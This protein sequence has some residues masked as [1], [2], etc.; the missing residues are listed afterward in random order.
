[1]NV[2]TTGRVVFALA[3]ATCLVALGGLEVMSERTWVDHERAAVTLR[4]QVGEKDPGWDTITPPD[5]P[6]PALESSHLTMSVQN[7]R[8]TVLT[9]DESAGR[10]RSMS[11]AGHVT[12]SQIGSPTVL[13]TED[14]QTTDLA[15]LRAG[16]IIRVEPTDGTIQRIVLLRHAWQQLE[17][18]EQ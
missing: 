9:M 16:D 11:G 7:G 4:P 1:M 5:T 2:T 14:R 8:V 13:V 3:V 15:Q 17:S 18:P 6:D 10:L 12:E